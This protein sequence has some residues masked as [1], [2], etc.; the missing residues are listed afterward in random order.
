VWQ[1]IVEN[2]NLQ[3]PGDAAALRATFIITAAVFGAE[4]KSLSR[5]LMT[6]V[7]EDLNKQRIGFTNRFASFDGTYTES[8]LGSA[9]STRA[10][11][12][13][14]DEPHVYEINVPEGASS[15]KAS[16]RAQPST[17]ADVDL[18]LYFCANQCELKAFSA[19]VGVEEKVTFAQPKGG[20]WKVV[21]DPVSI[22]S[23]VLAVDYTD[24]FTHPAF[25]SLTSRTTDV[26]LPNAANADIEMTARVDAQPVGN[27]RLV[28]LVE[29][30]TSEAGT[31]RYEYNAATKKVEPVKERVPL[32][33]ALLELRVVVIK[34]KTLTRAA[35]G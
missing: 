9:F 26:A 22:P 23:G 17:G 8:P 6:A 27:R 35:G 16:V 28:A 29:L 14:G 4:S 25:G 12:T 15:L 3:A 31:V 10:S 18:Y 19:R 2:Q 34:P 32:A 1:V 5:H 13:Q 11:M 7:R 24:V 33:Q 20:K 21:I 30:M